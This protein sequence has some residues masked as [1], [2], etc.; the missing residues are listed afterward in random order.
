MQMLELLSKLI[1]QLII[2]YKTVSNA[3]NMKTVAI[4]DYFDIT[5]VTC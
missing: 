4:T 3:T 1:A 5:V 2:I